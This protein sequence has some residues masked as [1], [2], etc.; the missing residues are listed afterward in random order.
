LL[1]NV[2]NITAC[3]Q[4]QTVF[5]VYTIYMFIKVLT[6]P[7]VNSMKSVSNNGHFTWH[8][9]ILLTIKP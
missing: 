1:H 4:M 2:T 7:K 5:T 6:Q 3:F 9:T 8:H